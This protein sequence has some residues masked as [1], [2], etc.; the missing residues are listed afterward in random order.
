MLLAFAAEGGRFVPGQGTK[1]PQTTWCDQKTKTKLTFAHS[2]SRW[3]ICLVGEPKGSD[4]PGRKVNELLGCSAGNPTPSRGEVT[5]SFEAVEP[6]S[7]SPYPRLVTW[8]RRLGTLC[9]RVALPHPQKEAPSRRPVAPALNGCLCK[10]IMISSL[11]SF[12]LPPANSGTRHR[13]ND[14]D[15]KR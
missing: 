3:L 13:A 11:P 10:D 1:I 15:L 12:L 7:P 5:V 2:A 6:E 8:Q 14:M 9:L 4:L